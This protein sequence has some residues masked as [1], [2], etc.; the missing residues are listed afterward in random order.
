MLEGPSAPLASATSSEGD[1]SKTPQSSEKSWL[2][3]D[4]PASEAAEPSEGEHHSEEA[5]LAAGAIVTPLQA[6]LTWKSSWLLLLVS[7][8][9]LAVLGQLV[10]PD[11][12][13]AQLASEMS[14]LQATVNKLL[15]AQ[16]Q[17]ADDDCGSGG[18]RDHGKEGGS[19]APVA[20]KLIVFC[21]IVAMVVGRATYVIAMLNAKKTLR[22]EQVKT[23]EDMTEKMATLQTTVEKRMDKMMTKETM[24]EQLSKVVSALREEMDEEHAKKDARVAQLESEQSVLRGFIDELRLE[25]G[26]MKKSQDDERQVRTKSM[27]AMTEKMATK[28]TGWFAFQRLDASERLDSIVKDVDA[29]LSAL[30]EMCKEGQTQLRAWQTMVENKMTTVDEQLGQVRKATAAQDA[31]PHQWADQEAVRS[32]QGCRCEAHRSRS[33]GEDRP[34]HSPEDDD[35]RRATRRCERCALETPAL[36][37]EEPA[38]LRRLHLSLRSRL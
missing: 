27:E 35:D 37:G 18:G 20:W 25:V 14:V 1:G 11:V 32:W 5:S 17:T 28:G 2:E 4:L 3:V 34:N 8:G 12:S 19:F 31:A 9:T 33:R 7:L 15:D 38:R 36:P 16:A 13:V 29:K 22:Q 26:S 24:D 6:P 21:F 10:K 30:K 23:R